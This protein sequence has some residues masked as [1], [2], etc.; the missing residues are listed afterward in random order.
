MAP[1]SSTNIYNRNIRE[2]RNTDTNT[3]ES[4]VYTS[5]QTTETIQIDRVTSTISIRIPV[6]YKLKYLDLDHKAKQLFKLGV[7]AL[8]DALYSGSEH[9]DMNPMVFNININVNEAKAESKPEINVNV[10]LGEIV[11]LVAKLYN[12]R[13]PLPPLQRKLIETL[14]KKIEKMV[15]RN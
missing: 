9:I 10:D 7:I 15:V 12:Y 3:L 4:S 8:I 5:K 6:S 1:T 14:Y 11:R 2:S 13:D